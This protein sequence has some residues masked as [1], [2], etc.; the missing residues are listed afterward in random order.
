MTPV[1]TKRQSPGMSV[2]LGLSVKH[3]TFKFKHYLLISLRFE[4]TWR[5]LAVKDDISIAGRNQL[6]VGGRQ[7][8]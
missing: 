6:Q 5:K 2:Q 1:L 4:L 8:F 7:S 3:F